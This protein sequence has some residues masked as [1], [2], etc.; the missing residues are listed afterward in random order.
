MRNRDRRI[1]LHRLHRPDSSSTDRRRRRMSHIRLTQVPLESAQ[2]P[3]LA[4]SP[5]IDNHPPAI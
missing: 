2:V 3:S 4:V 5:L 1:G